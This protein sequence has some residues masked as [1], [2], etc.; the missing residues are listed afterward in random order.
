MACEIAKAVELKHL[1]DQ[2]EKY[3]EPIGQCVSLEVDFSLHHEIGNKNKK[4]SKLEEIHYALQKIYNM[5]TVRMEREGFEESRIQ[6]LGEEISLKD[7]KLDHI[8]KWYK[9]GLKSGFGNVK[10]QE[11]QHNDSVRSSRELDASQFAVTK[12][13]LDEVTKKW[14]ETYV[15]SDSY[16]R[17]LEHCGQS[18]VPQSGITVEPYKIVLYGPGDH[19]QFHKDTPEENLCGTFLISLYDKC[20]PRGTFE[21]V[22]D[23]GSEFWS[24]HCGYLNRPANGFCAFYPDIP[25]RVN[26]LEEGYRAVLSFK[27]FAQ[28]QQDP[29]PEQS[30]DSAKA[31]QIEHLLDKLRELD[32]P[33]GILLGHHYGYDSKSIY[34]CDKLLIDALSSNGFEFNFKPVVVT[35]YGEG[36]YPAYESEPGNVQTFVYS[37]TNEDLDI[38][39]EKS[40]SGDTHRK[41]NVKAAR[42]G[43]R[44]LDGF[45]ESG[46]STGLW[47]SSEEEECEHTGNEARPYSEES[48]YVRYAA[49]VESYRKGS[50]QLP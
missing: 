24:S 10:T 19:F 2:A 23:G 25:H 29:R 18:F 3:L 1:V 34:G 35:L 33:L 14:G 27:I 45:V 49:I 47:S 5:R 6:I 22:Q 41:R 32:A 13:V 26:T 50:E 36:N 43:I 16:S 28:N 42:K 7:I 30:S 20:K 15:P 38:I 9:V 4:V 12:E 11:T 46:K 39:R 21:I 17:Y 31:I 8:E 40:K 48:V 44:F 37:I